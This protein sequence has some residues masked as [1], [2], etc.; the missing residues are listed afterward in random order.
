MSN[1]KAIQKSGGPGQRSMSVSDGGIEIIRR[2]KPVAGSTQTGH[3]YLL[4]DCSVSMRGS[5]ITQAKSGALNFAKSALEKGYDTG[6]I[7]FD[8]SARLLCEPNEDISVLEKAL[9]KINI[10]DVT[11]MAKAVDKAYKLLKDMSGKRVIVVVTDGMPNGEGDPRATLKTAD[12]AKNDGIDI[13][14]IGT[15]DAN[16]EFLKRIASRSDLAV[17]TANIQLGKTIGDA[18]L[19][20]PP[21]NPRNRLT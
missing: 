7:Q 14:A 9:E 18:A 15:D 10:G 21:G 16:K 3:V 19:L 8:S 1:D 20:L 2:G 5:K 13:I 12:I 4:V 6:L 11:H 17:K